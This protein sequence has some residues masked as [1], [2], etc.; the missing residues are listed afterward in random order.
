[1]QHVTSGFTQTD[2]HKNRIILCT[3]L[4][5]KHLS[6]AWANFP[7]EW[8]GKLIH[9]GPQMWGKYSNETK[10]AERQTKN[11]KTKG[12]EK[13][14]T[15]GGR[16][17]V[18]EED[19]QL[20]TTSRAKTRLEKEEW[21]WSR[22]VGTTPALPLPKILPL[23]FPRSSFPAETWRGKAS[24]ALPS[25]ICA[26][27]GFFLSLSFPLHLISPLSSFLFLLLF[28]FPPPPLPPPPS[29]PPPPPF[30]PPP[31]PL[32]PPPSC[33]TLLNQQHVGLMET[34]P[35]PTPL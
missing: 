27:P 8:R 5:V 12:K 11:V 21:T 16:E 18:A 28:A 30:P 24:R 14:K 29:S 15:E 34:R 17:G 32:L 13:R 6:H 10:Q 35:W 23:S 3:F 4:C 26:S 1:M 33:L 7:E 20:M 22:S 2:G 31:P 25:S 19:L 9:L